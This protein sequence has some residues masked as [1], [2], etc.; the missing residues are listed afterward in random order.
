MNKLRMRPETTVSR[1]HLQFRFFMIDD[2]PNLNDHDFL[3]PGYLF[4][5]SKQLLLTP[6]EIS[7]DKKKK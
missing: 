7:E 3:N 2:G 1:Y 5:P 6:K 4:V